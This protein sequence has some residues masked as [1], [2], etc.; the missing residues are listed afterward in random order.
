MNNCARQ[1]DETYRTSGHAHKN[2]YPSDLIVGWVLRNFRKGKCLDVGCGWGNNLRFLLAEGFEAFG[3]DFA[4]AAID[5]IK[6]EFGNRVRCE[7]ITATSWPSNTFDFIID[8]SSIQHNHIEELPVIFS[9]VNRIL[10]PGGRFFST[11]LKEGDN[12]FLLACPNEQ[13]LRDA[14]MV[15]S[16]VQIDYMTRTE[17]NQATTFVSYLI[18]ATK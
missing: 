5:G 18:D 9:E 8:R 17:N 16:S 3:I 12:G 10:K 11:M 15:F 2:K 6:P 14:L 1:W 13:A 4:A 7:S